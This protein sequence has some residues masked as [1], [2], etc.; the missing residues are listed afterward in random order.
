MR[1]Q[2]FG[3]L[4]A[5]AVLLATEAHATKLVTYSF[6]YRGAVCAG[7]QVGDAVIDLS[8]PAKAR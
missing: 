7:V 3:L 4:L 2:R 5:V 6:L 8:S 1:V